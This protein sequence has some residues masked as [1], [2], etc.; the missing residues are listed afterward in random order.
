M[1]EE[2]ESREISA[3]EEELAETIHR[4]VFNE[5]L[6]RFM[7]VNEIESFSKAMCANG[8]MLMVESL[9]VLALGAV[10]SAPPE[11]SDEQV[12]QDV[13]KYGKSMTDRFPEIL[14]EVLRD[15]ITHFRQQN[16]KK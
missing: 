11:I 5:Y 14:E 4:E 12:I 13:I 1:Q 9:R 16:P 10:N 2:T 3:L 15:R 8:V 7:E 6:Q